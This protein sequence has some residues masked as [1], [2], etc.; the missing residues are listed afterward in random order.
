MTVVQNSESL[1]PLILASTVHDIKNS[2]GSL[3]GLIQKLAV[4]QPA[5]ELEDILKLEFEAN[6]INH[7][8][9]QLLVMYRIDSHK[10]SLNS[11]EYPAIDLILEAKAQQARVLQ[12]N[13][14]QVI[15]ECSEDLLCYC[16][17]QYI[18]NALGTILNNAQ[19]YT[20]EKILLSASQQNDYVRFCI[21]DDGQ[22]YP[23]HLLDA[24]LSNPAEFDWVKGNTGLGLYFV[25]AI[26]GFH[27]NR[28]LSGYVKIDN[29]SRIGGARFCLYLP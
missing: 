13:S 2:L 15:V 5:D 28:D 17:Y 10:F 3:Q 18:C 6:R 14:T 20:G 22:G 16:D 24:D 29:D 1:F 23:A 9:M 7:S 26:A 27:K 4:K 21:E 19:R 12:T 11:D 25:S 8:L